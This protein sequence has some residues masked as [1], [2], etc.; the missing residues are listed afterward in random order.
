MRLILLL[1]VVLALGGCDKQKPEGQQGAVESSEDIKGVHRDQAG[2]PAPDVT[3]HDPDGGDISLADFRGSKALLVVFLCAH[4][5]Y[6][7][8]VRP[9]LARI[10]ADYADRGVGKSHPGRP[11][12][13]DQAGTGEEE[14]RARG[15]AT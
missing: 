14:R 11:G 13:R 6:V 8:H 4:C 2:E 5:P 15:P 3:F 12:D 1:L 10:A 9:E 7:V